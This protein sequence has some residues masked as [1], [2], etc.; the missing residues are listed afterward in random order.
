MR[1]LQFSKSSPRRGVVAN[2]MIHAP[3]HGKME[4]LTRN[5]SHRPRPRHCAGEDDVRPCPAPMQSST[6]KLVRWVASAAVALA[7]LLVLLIPFGR[8]EFDWHQALR[9]GNEEEFISYLESWPNGRHAGQARD[10]IEK[11]HWKKAQGAKRPEGIRQFLVD[12]PNGRFAEDARQ[13]LAKH[14]SDDTPFLHAKG[15]H[16]IPALKEFLRENPGHARQ[17]DALAEIESLQWKQALA[18]NRPASINEFLA[19]YPGGRFAEDAQKQLAK[20]LADDAPFLRAKEARSVPAIEEFQKQYPGHVRQADAAALRDTLI[21]ARNLGLFAPSAYQAVFDKAVQNIA[22][23][24]QSTLQTTQTSQTERSQTKS[25]T[26]WRDKDIL[27]MDIERP[28]GKAPRVHV[29]TLDRTVVFSV[30]GGA[31][32]AIETGRNGISV[33]VKTPVKFR[34]SDAAL[35]VNYENICAVRREIAESDVTIN[36]RSVSFIV[37]L[38]EEHGYDVRFALQLSSGEIRPLDPGG[39]GFAEIEG[40]PPTL[41]SFLKECNKP[42]SPAGQDRAAEST[43]VKPGDQAL[44]AK[45]A[46]ESSNSI[47]SRVAINNLIDQ[48]LLAKV[49]VEAASSDARCAAVEKLSATRQDVLAKIAVTDRDPSVRRAGVAKLTDPAMLMNVGME[50]KD[51]DIRRAA[52][53]KLSEQASMTKATGTQSGWLVVAT[54]TISK[55]TNQDW[56]C[57]WAGTAP[58]AAIRQAAVRGVT[59]E[60]FLVQH[61]RTESSASVR[62]AIIETLRGND[63]L[64]DVALTAYHEDDRGQ[65]LGRLKAAS[66][67]T[68]STVAT[69]FAELEHRTQSLASETDENKLMTLAL[70][71]QF[72]VLQTAAARRLSS[73]VSVEKTVLRATDREVLK[74]LLEKLQDYSALNRVAETAPN[75]ALR[76]AASQ[77]AGTRSWTEIFQAAIAHGVSARMLG[78]AL[79]AVAFSPTVQLDAKESVQNACL[80]LIRLGDESRIPEMVDLLEGYGDTRLAEDYLNC[81]QPDL[82]KAARRWASRRGCPVSTGGGTSRARWGI[83]K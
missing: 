18:S 54:A 68:A 72:D 22:T 34:G 25:E 26:E 17:L 83:A 60:K 75:P 48:A 70:E 50:S 81:G 79:A 39:N 42:D 23:V 31:V 2:G 21:A 63:A 3:N 13:Q 43:A 49:A 76:L 61:L 5:D 35:L 47:T 64:R 59:D 6:K 77:K 19:A 67:E 71:G 29:S 51:P 38:S 30:A 8:S 69:A 27:S 1:G 33:Q 53:D 20:L 82:D 24:Q 74:I 40:L 37:G 57:Q 58:Q 7:A 16:S 80:N 9:A 66:P 28:G 4:S 11:L 36:T 10:A 62:A 65:A 12:H 78:D 14:L 56:L 41:G 15:A 52:M 55:V 32:S 73:S 45:V 46:A 44:L